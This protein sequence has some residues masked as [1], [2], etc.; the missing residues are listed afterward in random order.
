MYA[1]LPQRVEVAC[2]LNQSQQASSLSNVKPCA[3]HGIDEVATLQRQW[4][5]GAW[6]SQHLKKRNI[7]NKHLHLT[8]SMGP[9][10][11]LSVPSPYDEDSRICADYL[12]TKQKGKQMKK[13][14]RNDSDMMLRIAGV[15]TG[16]HR[17]P[18]CNLC[19][20]A[21]NRRYAIRW[22]HTK[23]YGIP[24]PAETRTERRTVDRLIDKGLLTAH[25]STTDR[26]VSLTR[27]GVLMAWGLNGDTPSIL[28]EALDM[29]RD[30]IG[31]R[32]VTFEDEVQAF[33]FIRAAGYAPCWTALSLLG[34]AEV[35]WTVTNT[36][37][38][39]AYYSVRPTGETADFPADDYPNPDEEATAAFMD[40]L[41]E[42]E[43][44][45]DGG[46]PSGYRNEIGQRLPE[47]LIKSFSDEKQE[48]DF[49]AGKRL[50]HLDL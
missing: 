30:R 29:I 2:L 18:L 16:I 24:S 28:V 10:D 47:Y 37:E 25:G 48:L 8:P 3:T 36:T 23:A 43:Q 26:S 21:D 40:G 44:I 49:Y 33:P 4:V 1:V 19:D 31:R 7:I 35:G 38:E 41:H 34:L 12:W 45:A 11:C 14:D 50:F 6:A 9:W 46:L 5:L 20:N 42:G 17:T 32:F 22:Q 27:A 15:Y 39:R 13:T